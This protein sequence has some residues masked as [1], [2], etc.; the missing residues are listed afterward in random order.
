[1]LVSRHHI[2]LSSLLLT[3]TLIS[4]EIL[5]RG[6]WNHTV[7]YQI[8]PRSFMDTDNDGVGDLKGITS[9]LEHFVTSGVGAIWLS[10]INRSPM[11]D[12]GYDI[13]DFKDIDKTFGDLADFK[14]LL[15]RA[16]R[17]GLKVILDLVPNHTSDEH[18][19]F[20]QSINRI[21][22]YKDY[23][24]WKYGKDGNKSP[25]NN[26]LSVFGGSA[27]TL[28]SIRQQWYL[29]QFHEKQPDLNYAHPDVQEEMREIIL[30]WLR[31]GV[32]GFRVDAVPH[33]FETN[34]T[35]DE[36]ESGIKGATKTDYNFL[37]HILTTDQPET[38]KLKVKINLMHDFD[39]RIYH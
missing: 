29:H 26:W 6:W 21:G 7:F 1:M 10:P 4:G 37:N 12:F 25:P 22:K 14:F 20:Q 30:F 31:K 3:T 23:Y 36:P 5:N 28:N 11:V 2:I 17:F 8:Y 13:S 16:K 24:I 15:A 32:D 18:Y 19:W 34:Y 33:L 35:L 38:Y 39:V 27:W 9:K